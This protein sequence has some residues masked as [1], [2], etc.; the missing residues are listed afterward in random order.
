MIA[1]II[2]AG[3]HVWQENG[4]ESLGPR[5]LL[6]IANAPLIRHLLAWLREGGVR[7]IAIC[8]N[9][10][11]PALQAYLLDGAAEEV[12]V[13]YYEDRAPRGPAGCMRDAAQFAEADEFV[14]VDGSILPGFELR[15]LVQFHRQHEASA[16][17]VVER[18][19][20]GSAESEAWLHPVGIYVFAGRALESVPATGFQDTKETLIPRLHREGVPVVTFAAERPSPRV[21][22][23]A[24][25]LELQAWVL[26]RLYARE[27]TVEGYEWRNG[28]C[29]HRSAWIAP[30]ARILGPVMIGPQ[31]R[32]EDEAA[33]VGPTVI[34]GRCALH[35][36]SAVTR[37]VLWD[38]CV[39]SGRAV[40]D[41]CLMTT[42]TYLAPGEARHSLT[43][44]VDGDRALLGEPFEGIGS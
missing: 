29:L 13:Y 7:T 16:C 21:R 6:P 42:G 18:R 38:R 12:D 32:V 2:L 8:A 25:Y 27:L 36:R 31:S 14:V 24:S 22:G 39:V 20:R 43:C 5:L 33:I 41:H 30:R 17:V 28:V 35:R 1:G 26:G 11:S 40:V 10:G 34:G 15:S 4:F 19:A 3:S 44:S 23:L 9:E 37:S